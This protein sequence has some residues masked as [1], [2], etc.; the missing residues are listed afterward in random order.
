MQEYLINHGVDA[1][2]HYPIPMHLQAAA[3]E[4]GYLNGDFPISEA[5]ANTTL[6]LPVHEF[7][8]EEHVEKMI[9]LIQRFYE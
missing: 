9:S 4:Y 8:G 5:T 3:K 7:I 6:S 2:I 1:K